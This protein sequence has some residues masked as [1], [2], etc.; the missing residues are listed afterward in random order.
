[1]PYFTGHTG[2]HY[3]LIIPF[4]INVGI[5]KSNVVFCSRRGTLHYI[6]SVIFVQLF[7]KSCSLFLC[8]QIWPC[9]KLASQLLFIEVDTPMKST[10]LA[11]GYFLIFNPETIIIFISSYWYTHRVIMSHIILEL[12]PKLYM[13]K[14][15]KIS[16]ITW[17]NG[18]RWFNSPFA[19]GKLGYGSWALYIYR[20]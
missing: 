12:Y 9:K 20:E 19:I 1:M 13:A 8:L 2:P 11:T 3:L 14:C 6:F 5:Y 18:F 15:L 4:T 10:S 17:N 7:V 16:E